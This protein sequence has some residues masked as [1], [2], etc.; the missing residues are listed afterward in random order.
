VELR[1]VLVVEDEPMVRTMLEV[2]LKRWGFEP[3]AVKDGADAQ[4]RLGAGLRPC[5]ILMN[6][7]LPH[8]KAHAFREWQRQQPELCEIPVIVISG[9]GLPEE[10]RTQ[11]EAAGYLSK[12][13]NFSALRALL[14]EHC[15][16]V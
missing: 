2:A 14:A 16:A 6:L 13:I 9:G 12:P 10:L 4:E 5:V 8:F 3:V 7:N 15:P 11:L 1:C